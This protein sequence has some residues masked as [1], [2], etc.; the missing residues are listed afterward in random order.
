MLVYYIYQLGFRFQD[1]GYAAAVSMIL[2]VIL[3][4]ISVTQMRFLRSD[5]EY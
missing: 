2:L 4:L 3:L 5:V 1:M